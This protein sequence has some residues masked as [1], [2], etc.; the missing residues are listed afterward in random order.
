MADHQLGLPTPPKAA[1]ASYAWTMYL[2]TKSIQFYSPDFMDAVAHILHAHPTSFVALVVDIGRV[3]RGFDVH[4]QC[5]ETILDGIESRLYA[6]ER[7]LSTSAVRS[8]PPVPVLERTAISGRVRFV[9]KGDHPYFM[10][11]LSMTDVLLQ[12]MPLDG[13]TTTLEAVS[14]ATPTVLFEGPAIGGRMGQAIYRH[15]NVTRNIARSKDEY[16]DIAV[17]LGRDR[18]FNAALRREVAE[19]RETHSV[20]QDPTA[21]THLASWLEEAVRKSNGKTF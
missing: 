16:V 17:R 4:N 18:D 5:Q 3:N 19:K 1:G 20:Y 21:I 11:L 14:L 9:D 7:G 2:V 12:P 6:L 15:M 8:S 13:T 10:S